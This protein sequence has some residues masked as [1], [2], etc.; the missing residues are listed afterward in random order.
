[1]VPYRV[2]NADGTFAMGVVLGVRDNSRYNI[3]KREAVCKVREAGESEKPKKARAKKNR[4]TGEMVEEAP[5]EDPV[6][7]EVAETTADAPETAPV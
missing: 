5:V 6:L 3:S 7:I 4:D 1:M 2:C